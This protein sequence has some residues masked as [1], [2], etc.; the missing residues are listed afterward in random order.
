MTDLRPVAHPIGKIIT[1]MGATMLLP[2]A[3]DLWHG[4]DHGWVFLESAVITVVLG[5]LI[6]TATQNHDGRLTVRQAFLLTSG[7]WAVLPVVGAVPLMLGQ[8]GASLT[9]AYFEAM[10]G[11]T[12]TGTTVFPE[13]NGLPRGTHL[14]RAILQWLGGL[15]IVV[16]AMIFL[17]AMKVGG[18]QFFRSEGFDTGGKSLPRA[19][20][21]ALEI[22]LV[23][24][25]M[26]VACALTYIMLGMTGFDAIIHA[27]TT[28]STG[29][30]SNYDASFGAYIGGPEWAAVV[31]MLMAS[32]P[33]IRMVQLARGDAAPIWQDV[34][35]RA[36]L[37]WVA[38]ACAAIILFRL[39]MPPATDAPGAMIRETVFNTVSTFSGTGYASANLPGWGHFPV[40]IL[41]LVGLIG[42][43]T[44]STTCSVK[45]FRYLVL[46]Q[47]VRAQIRRMYSPH[48]VYPLRYEGRPL[49]GDVVNSV[50]AFFTLFMLSFGLLIVGLSLTGLHPRTALTGAWTA[51]ANV[52]HVWGPEVTANGSVANLPPS[53]KW[54]M[55]IGMYLGRLELVAVLVLFLPRFWRD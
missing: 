48:R 50:M 10:S 41:V 22:T 36:Y 29:G 33:F 52:G 38:Y 28:C 2:M 14:W 40:V 26:T 1:A 11:F 46:L 21:I 31:F 35:I 13:L 45:V 4:D 23:Y 12:T 15:G 18:M 5:L 24:A 51:I 7:L 16:V 19:G 43:C 6:A 44:G 30:F 27:L 17:P 3:V 49:D 37:R 47:A 53:A 42:G 34:Q 8:P 54:L 55:I 25:A 32:V 39:V 9:D 20:E